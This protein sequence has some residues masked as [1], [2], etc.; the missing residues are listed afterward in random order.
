M[1]LAFLYYFV[2][3]Y[4]YKLVVSGPAQTWEGIS[5]S[6]RDNDDSPVDW[7]YIYKPPADKLDYTD[8]GS[9]FIYVTSRQSDKRWNYPRKTIMGNSLLYNTL[10]PSY[11]PTY[12][13]HMASIFFEVPSTGRRTNQSMQGFMLADELGGV[14]VLHTVPGFPTSYTK[15]THW[16]SNEL[17]HG[18]L[19]TCLSLS[20]EDL[21]YAGATIA[22]LSPT[23]KYR[24]M[25][26]K[27]EPALH[28]WDFRSKVEP[29]K[30]FFSPLSTKGGQQFILYLRTPRTIGCLY[31]TFAKEHEQMM[32]VYGPGKPANV[33]RPRFGI[34]RIDMICLKE[35]DSSPFY[36]NQDFNEDKISFGVSTAASWQDTLTS[37]PE[38][39]TCIS[40]LAMS[41][42]SGAPGF[43]LCTNHYEI[44]QAF[45]NL[46]VAEPKC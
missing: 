31:R 2:F 43:M 21:V 32:N 22:R 36:I 8:D 20:L 17:K 13:A 1:L 37:K 46:K 35:P 34:R 45:D 29:H 44:W 30:I 10:A 18:H 7:W 42:S 26:G 41:D 40:N 16:P 14:L 11:R 24:Q 5:I 3:A 25:P 23:V 28:S 39:W 38:Y 9:P 27:L 33:C 15:R 12:S 4:L 6:C 19:F